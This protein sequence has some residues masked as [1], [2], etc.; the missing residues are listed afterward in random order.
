MSACRMI[1]HLLM[2]YEDHGH[3]QYILDMSEGQNMKSCNSLP[4]AH[5]GNYPIVFYPL[6]RLWTY[7]QH[8]MLCIDDNY[9]TAHSKPAVVCFPRF[10]N[11]HKYG[12]FFIL[13]GSLN[14]LCFNDTN[15]NKESMLISK[16]ALWSI[17]LNWQNFFWRSLDQYRCGHW[18]QDLAQLRNPITVCLVNDSSLCAS[19]EVIMHSCPPECTWFYYKA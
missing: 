9:L 7:R 19:I 1:P 12:D 16:R 6:Q 2:V 11:H 8:T 13:K 5:A 10:H 4:V 3:V 18:A 15:Y 17:K 14:K